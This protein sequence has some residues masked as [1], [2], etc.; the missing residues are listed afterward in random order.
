MKTK[1]YEYLSFRVDP[2]L[3][4]R[5]RKYAYSNDI[6]VGWVCRKGLVMALDSLENEKKGGE[7]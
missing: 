2:E 1:K 4:S 6:S 7:S 3:L 5:V